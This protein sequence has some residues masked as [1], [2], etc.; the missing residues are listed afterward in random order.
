MSRKVLDLSYKLHTQPHL[1]YG[2][3]IYHNQRE[4]SMKLIEQ[5]QY[6]A[7][8]IVS[9]CWQ[10]TSRSKLYDELVWESMPDGR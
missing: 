9:G 10:G 6:N 5:T 8:L 1:D 4:D 7:A 2:D 3:E